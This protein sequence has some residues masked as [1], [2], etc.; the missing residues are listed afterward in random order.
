MTVDVAMHGPRGAVEGDPVLLRHLIGNLLG[1][2]I[3]YNHPGGR[4]L[5]A[6]D[7]RILT[8][9]NTGPEVPSDRLGDLSEPFRRLARDRVGHH[10]GH[11]LGLSI[12]RSIAD[13]HGAAL[14]AVPGPQGSLRIE[15]SRTRCPRPAGGRT[16]QLRVHPDGPGSSLWS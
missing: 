4:G 12:V 13:A 11:G 3:R 8:V 5:L 7:R 2:A 9:T 14:T 10:A 16:G 15:A 1:D 6:L